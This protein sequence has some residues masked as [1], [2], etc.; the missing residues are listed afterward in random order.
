MIFHCGGVTNYWNVVKTFQIIFIFCYTL[1][2]KNFH[3]IIIM[4]IIII[5]TAQQQ[6]QPHQQPQP[7][8]QPKQ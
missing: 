4:N 6:P 1:S 5:V 2:P 7:Q 3:I 8:Q